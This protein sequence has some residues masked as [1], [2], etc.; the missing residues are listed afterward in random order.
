[1]VGLLDISLQA[2]V[3][4]L[5][6]KKYTISCDVNFDQVCFV[7]QEP[8]GAKTTYKGLASIVESPGAL[9]GTGT[10]PASNIYVEITGSGGGNGLVGG[11]TSR[12]YNPVTSTSVFEVTS[13]TLQQLTRA[14]WEQATAP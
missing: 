14:A 7:V 12:C 13:N 2:Q 3:A 10:F 1:M 4:E 5:P 6:P 9:C 11:G 8:S